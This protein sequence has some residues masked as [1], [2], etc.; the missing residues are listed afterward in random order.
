MNGAALAQIGNSHSHAFMGNDSWDKYKDWP[1]AVVTIS[2]P[3]ATNGM[4][5]ITLA[6]IPDATSANAGN[7]E[8]DITHGGFVALV[9]AEIAPAVLA[10]NSDFDEGR[11]DPVTG[12]AIPDCDDENIA[13]EVARNHLNGKYAI[14]ERVTDDMLPGFFG[15]K[16]SDLSNDF[17]T[18]A[19]ITISKINQLDPATGHPEIGHVRFYGKWG[20][21]DDEDVP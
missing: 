11:I 9:P 2:A 6:F 19:N 1:H 10:V 21:W 13:L 4:T 3:D 16:P 20:V 15:L 5:P 14:N 18:S 8:V 12:Y 17:W 7:Q